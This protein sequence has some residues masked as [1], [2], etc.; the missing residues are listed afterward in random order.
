MPLEPYDEK[1]LKDN[2]I[3]YKSFH[4]WL[5]QIKVKNSSTHLAALD[6][7][8]LKVK[9]PCGGAHA[10]FPRGLCS[11]CQPSS[12]TLS[13]QNFRMVDHVEFETVGVVEGFLSQW[14]KTGGLFETNQFNG[15]GT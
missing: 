1:Y 2:K 8:D 9:V 13:A 5:K 15:L 11:K 10:P 14:R 12:L 6:V 3:K 7:L 4:S